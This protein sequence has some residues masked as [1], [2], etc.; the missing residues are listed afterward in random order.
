MKVWRQ[1]IDKLREVKP[2]CEI[3]VISLMWQTQMSICC[4]LSFYWWHKKV[5]TP[6][7]S[8]RYLWEKNET[9]ITH[10]NMITTINM[11]D[12]LYNLTEIINCFWNVKDNFWNYAQKCQSWTITHLN[13]VVAA[14]CFLGFSQGG[15]NYEQFRISVS[16]CTKPACLFSNEEHV[17][18]SLVE[19]LNFIGGP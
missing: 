5:Y 16:V 14:S 12:N 6:L 10:L 13:M 11:I 3:A 8:C 4:S 9:K 7:F 17:K 18:T 1:M 15:V 19:Q 2:C